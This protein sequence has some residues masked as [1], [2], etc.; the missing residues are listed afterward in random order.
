[1]DEQMHE[2]DKDKEKTEEKIGEE[3]ELLKTL[4]I[5]VNNRV[6]PDV[7]RVVL[8]TAL[9]VIALFMVIFQNL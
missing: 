7:A 2:V 5:K 3:E 6:L 9:R 8:Q 1:M 4:K